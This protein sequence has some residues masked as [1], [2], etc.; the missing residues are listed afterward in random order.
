[1]LTRA[2]VAR[3][4]APALVL[5]LLAL[6]G[7]CGGGGSTNTST[8]AFVAIGPEGG[9]L[10]AGPAKVTI[11]PGA[12]DQPTGVSLLPQAQPLPIE[13]PAADPCTYDYYGPIYC[14][15]PVGRALLVNGVL[16]MG[17]DDTQLPAGATEADLVLLE[18]DDFN[19]VM[20]PRPQPP[21]VQNTVENWFEDPAYSHLGH[22]AIGLRSCPGRPFRRDHLGVQAAPARVVKPDG[23]RGTAAPAVSTL[24]VLDVTLPASVVQVPT[25]GL[26][27]QLWVPSPDGERILFSSSDPVTE[28]P[29]LHTVRV[30]GQGAPVLLATSDVPAGVFLQGSSPLFGWLAAA[31]GAQVF[32]TN[33]VNPSTFILPTGTQAQLPLQRYE[34][35]RRPGDGS[36]AATLLHFTDASDSFLDDLRQSGDGSHLM[37]HSVVFGQGPNRVDVVLSPSGTPVSLAVVPP[38]D[39]SQTP[40]FAPGSDDLTLPDAGGQQANRYAPGGA[41]LATLLDLADYEGSPVVAIQDFALAPDGQAF[42]AVVDLDDDGFQTSELWIGTLGTGIDATYFFDEPVFVQ[43]MI[44]HPQ[45]TGVF[46]DLSGLGVALYALA[47]GEGPFI[48]LRPVPADSLAD[49][50]V[51]RLDGRIVALLRSTLLDESGLGAGRLPDGLYLGPADASAFEPLTPAGLGTI[52]SARWLQSWRLTA[53]QG[54]ARVR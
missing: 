31:G 32:F 28:A 42:A 7:A 37:A 50:D 43:E 47:Q 9:T 52:L 8:F 39:G 24:H 54:D 10:T 11:P 13:A 17:Y 53:G 51:N 26:D 44:W 21:V 2:P 40:R 16:R 5:G 14:C 30:D 45:Q 23:A 33:Y 18:W 38:S 27:P 4:R 49:V 46:L 19:G 35:L 6:L 36:A 41:F 20:R 3:F 12:L 1:M 15:G 25:G 29:L 48:E 34:V 22:L